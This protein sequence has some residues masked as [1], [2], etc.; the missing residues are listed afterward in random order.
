[1]NSRQI[2]CERVCAPRQL[3]SM[4]L[5]FLAFVLCRPANAQSKPA[6]SAGKQ[7]APV[8]SDVTFASRSELVLVPVVI[9]DH[10][11]AHVAGLK[12]DDFSIK[13]DGAERNISVFEEIT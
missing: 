4:L 3:I 11:G 13:E 9:H 5:I 12:K 2:E 10:H 1:M 7:D 8:Q 6:S